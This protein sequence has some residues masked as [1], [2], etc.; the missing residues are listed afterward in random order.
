M[1]RLVGAYEKGRLTRLSV[2][3]ME[4]RS[5]AVYPFLSCILQHPSP[6]S[7]SSRQCALLQADGVFDA[8]KAIPQPQSEDSKALDP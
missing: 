3:L 2:E 1:P 6:K 5:A 7:R 8:F 4:V